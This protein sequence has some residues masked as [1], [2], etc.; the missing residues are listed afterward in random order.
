[1]SKYYTRSTA[2]LRDELDRLEEQLESL[3]EDCPDDYVSRRN[4]ENLI[5]NVC[6]LLCRRECA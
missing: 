3:I 6:N 4:L 1:M 2:W 5:D